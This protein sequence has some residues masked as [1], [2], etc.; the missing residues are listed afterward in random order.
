MD[1]ESDGIDWL[2]AADW[3]AV[4]DG[5]GVFWLWLPVTGGDRDIDR[6]NELTLFKTEELA[7]PP[8]AASASSDDGRADELGGGFCLRRTEPWVDSAA[9]SQVI[10]R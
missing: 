7:V 1:G 2:T 10:S 8:A 9:S 4:D 5:G 3:L 6:L